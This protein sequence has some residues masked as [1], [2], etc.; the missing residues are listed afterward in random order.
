MTRSFTSASFRSSRLEQPVS[1]IDAIATS[2]SHKRTNFIG[3]DS[4]SEERDR[5]GKGAESDAY[6][7]GKALILLAKRAICNRLFTSSK[8]RSGGWPRNVTAKFFPDLNKIRRPKV[9]ESRAQAC[10]VRAR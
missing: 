3:R 9:S 2:P 5:T 10:G 6:R 4:F 1:A 7:L 8:T